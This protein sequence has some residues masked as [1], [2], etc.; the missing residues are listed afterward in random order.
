VKL[1][2]LVVTAA[3]VVLLTSC[4]Q[5]CAE[6]VKCKE[7]E[8]QSPPAQPPAALA[9][10]PTGKATSI[11][12]AKGTVAAETDAAAD[13]SIK[14]A[15]DTAA[16]ANAEWQGKTF[17]D[18][19]ATVTE[20]KCG[21][22]S[23]YIVNGD[24][25]IYDIKHLREFFE[26][27]IQSPPPPP[28]TAMVNGA[29]RNV[30]ALVVATTTGADE[31]IWN[32][33]Q[34]TQISYCVSNSFN[35]KHAQVVGDMARAAG[36][37]ERVADVKFVY[38]QQ[39][40]G[41]CDAS[42]NNVVFDVRPVNVDGRY[43]ARAF[44]PNEP[45]AGRNVFIDLSALDLSPG[46]ALTLEG[47]LRHEL[48]HTLGFR[49]EHTR[50]EA[51][52]C[53]EDNDFKPITSYDKFS[54][55]HYPHC[56][57]GADWELRLTARD[58]SGVACVYGKSATFVIDTALCTPRVVLPVPSDAPVTVNHTAQSVA[59]EATQPY[60][61]LIAKPGSIIKFQMKGSGA[62]P[63]DP[64]LYVN[65]GPQAPRIAP[66]RATCRPYLTGAAESC[67][68]T[69]PAAPLNKVQ[70]MVNGYTAG[71]YDLAISYVPAPGA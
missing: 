51:G 28:V 21:D 39:E 34:K 38:Q 24:I 57:G 33:E 16:A 45:R 60:T 43:Y 41:R 5:E 3:A 7:C 47:V 23:K 44:F 49:H 67:E 27:K 42:N 54:V 46:E 64:D 61:A 35:S 19:L 4:Q 20:E 53:F 9:C 25:P 59:N 65:F 40:N 10:T 1:T 17:E 66:L 50:P 2:T 29:R 12:P 6:C 31:A 30:S 63:G 55:M 13:E 68:L 69:V 15:R 70:Y 52:T 14:S 11:R 36:A 26:T 71:S 48:G 37:W 62:S 56:N 18:F 8:V 22:E 58:K 32:S